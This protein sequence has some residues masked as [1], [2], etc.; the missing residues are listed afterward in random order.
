MLD[1][2]DIGLIDS[3]TDPPP[4]ECKLTVMDDGKH[5]VIP[6]TQP[7]SVVVFLLTLVLF[8]LGTPL[9]FVI[10]ESA[11]KQPG[12]DGASILPML[13]IAWTV[14][15]FGP[16]AYL[17]FWPTG[18]LRP[19]HWLRFDRELHVLS[20][21]GGWTILDYRSIV[22]LLAVTDLRKKQTEFQVVSYSSSGIEKHF[23]ASCRMTNPE[24]AF[25]DTLERFG[26]L[27]KLKTCYATISHE[28]MINQKCVGDEESDPPK[29]PISR[30]FE[31]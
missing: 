27:C 15:V 25:G 12:M 16:A 14:G 9:C 21:R 6:I 13:I 11:Q 22:C 26:S 28:G 7:S 1:P 17:L 10:Y 4:R 31:S 5:I 29:S 23:V 8:A 30:Q 19:D 3:D 18:M 20:I 24:H 2:S